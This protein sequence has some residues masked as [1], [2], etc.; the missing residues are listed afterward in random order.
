VDRRF[1]QEEVEDDDEEVAPE[2]VSEK[3]KGLVNRVS[4]SGEQVLADELYRIVDKSGYYISNICWTCSNVKDP[5]LNIDCSAGFKDAVAADEFAFDVVRPWR[6][7]PEAPDES[8]TL[9]I[10]QAERRELTRLLEAASIKAFT[11]IS[12]PEQKVIMPIKS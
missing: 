6:Y 10:S 4:L 8:E 1:P 12:N 11:A 3:I 7:K 2:E 9:H 5:R